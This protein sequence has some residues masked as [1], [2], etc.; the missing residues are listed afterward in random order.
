M[1]EESLV[2]QLLH[3]VRQEQIRASDVHQE[4]Q[5]SI[6]KFNEFLDTHESKDMACHEEL[7]AKLLLSFP[8]GD[9]T[10]HRKYHEN[11][12]AWLEL[13]NSLVRESLAMAAKTG[14]V[15]ALGWIGYALF[16]AAKM[17]LVSK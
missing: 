3:E 1:T 12:I 8:N 4:F 17:S 16:Q 10:G 6:D 7:E 9:T 14:G 2:L 15:A 13:R 11:I 5:K